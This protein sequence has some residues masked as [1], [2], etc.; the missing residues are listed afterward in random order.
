[1]KQTKITL[2]TVKAFIRKNTGNLYINV[3]SEFS[4]YSDSIESVKSN[5]QPTTPA[6]HGSFSDTLGIK[7]A[8]FVGMSRD[9]FES[10]DD[11][12]FSGIKVMNCCGSFILAVQK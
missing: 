6:I 3:K 9:Y 4:G 10:Y 1:M 8:W 7:G 11:G 12:H 5:F 2:S